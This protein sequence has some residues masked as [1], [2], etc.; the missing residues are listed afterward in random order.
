MMQGRR[1]KDRPP[2]PLHVAVPLKLKLRPFPNELRLECA[3]LRSPS[4]Y[5]IQPAEGTWRTPPSFARA[6]ALRPGLQPSLAAVPFIFWPTHPLL[7][8][9][10]FL[11]W[12]SIFFLPTGCA[13]NCSLVGAA[14]LWGFIRATGTFIA[15]FLI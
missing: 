4:K 14:R 10:F 11:F 2:P 12:S 1:K 7:F 6:Q 13:H 8:F 5:A 9:Y 3:S 15:S